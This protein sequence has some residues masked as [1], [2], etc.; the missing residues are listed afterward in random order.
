MRIAFCI[1]ALNL[2][3]IGTVAKNLSDYFESLGD[4][5]DIIT[6]HHKGNFFDIAKEK[7][8]PVIDI[9]NNDYSLKK[10]LAVT[11]KFLKNY[12]VIINN[13][14]D[15]VLYSLP[16]LPYDIIKI[17]VQHNTTK[18][19]AKK[20]SYNSEY[21]DY[22]CGVSPAVTEIIRE[23]V[24]KR[25][26]LMVMP[27]GVSGFKRKQY[28]PSHKSYINLVFIGRLSDK[29][30][31]IIQMLE[32]PYQLK[33]NGVNFRFKIIGDGEDRKVLISKIKK[34]RIEQ[35]VV[36]LGQLDSSDIELEIQDCDFLINLSHWEGL[37]MVVLESMSAGLIPILSPIKPHEYA[38]GLDLFNILKPKNN[39]ILGVVD[40][41]IELN[42][43][44]ELCFE[45]SN[46][47]HKRWKTYF[48][49]NAFGE[50]YKSLISKGKVSNFK[51]NILFDDLRIPLQERIKLLYIYMFFQKI[52]RLF[53]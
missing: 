31:N 18:K 28:I 16:L 3:G 32:I 13:H 30:K 23:Y 47:L 42:D 15:E 12:D 53:K 50:N 45:L 39:S 2:G 37:P 7:K 35:E 9:S 6:T 29:Q 48:S 14:S 24:P 17:S 52:I 10:R 20:L 26:S 49:L 21:I 40:K 51:E 11:A 43:N 34:L 8:W 44:P 36:L 5:F 19:A 33:K 38:L 46:K 22:Y 4:R 27:N 41:I 1:G 25:N